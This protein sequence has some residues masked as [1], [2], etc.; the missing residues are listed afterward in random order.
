MKTQCSVLGYR[1]DFYFHDYKIEIEVDEY[2][3]SDRNTDD[4]I[5]RQTAIE[6]ELGCEFIRINPDVS[7]FNIFTAI[8]EI[9][10]HIKKSSKRSLLDR[11]SKRLLELTFESHHSIKSRALKNVA[12]KYY[13]IYE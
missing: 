10:R 5:K 1:I 9:H 7:G 13:Q 4:E 8:N 11:I 3:H 12:K 2:G 6:K